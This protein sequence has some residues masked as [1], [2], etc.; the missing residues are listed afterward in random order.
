MSKSDNLNSNDYNKN[1]IYT[2]EVPTQEDKAKIDVELWL[3]YEWKYR[4]FA[5]L[6]G[7]VSL[8]WYESVDDVDS[9]TKN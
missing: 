9:K 8:I 5:M 7:G 4:F 6:K 1:Q 3:N 2:E